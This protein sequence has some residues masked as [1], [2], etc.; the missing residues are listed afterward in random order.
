MARLPGNQSTEAKPTTTAKTTDPTGPATKTPTKTMP[1]EREA[2]NLP[3]VESPAAESREPKMPNTATLPE[4]SNEFVFEDADRMPGAAEL[5]AETN[6]FQE[7]INELAKTGKATS[8]VRPDREV[9]GIRNQIR[10]AANNI[11]MSGQT[12]VVEVKG[13]PGFTRIWFSVRPKKENKN[14]AA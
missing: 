13:R 1:T 12:K 8:I 3:P 2:K 9:E 11:G 10:R 14:S 6:P 5:S 7:K 4:A